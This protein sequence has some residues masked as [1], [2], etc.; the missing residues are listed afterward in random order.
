MLTVKIFNSVHTKSDLSIIDVNDI[1]LPLVIHYLTGTSEQE[2]SGRSLSRHVSEIFIPAVY[3][4][5]AG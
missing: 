2:V 1:R 3:L 5:R 4:A